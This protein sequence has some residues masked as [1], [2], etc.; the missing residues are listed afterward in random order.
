MTDEQYQKRIQ[1]LEHIK[2][3][4]VAVKDK[5]LLFYFDDY[6]IS[7]ISTDCRLF[8][9]ECSMYQY[10]R[11]QNESG[12]VVLSYGFE[13]EILLSLADQFVEIGYNL[14][15]QF[16]EFNDLVKPIDIKKIAPELNELFKLLKS[17]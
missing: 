14:T 1:F 9:R 16:T 8:D 13:N 3:N 4:Y 17:K 11:S 2:K 5:V 12:A 7:T 6:D 10:E 15:Y